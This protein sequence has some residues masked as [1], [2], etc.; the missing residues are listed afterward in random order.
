[1]DSET[2]WDKIRQE[3]INA[4]AGIDPEKLVITTDVTKNIVG[5]AK[6]LIQ[7]QTI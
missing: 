4:T 2:N 5:E 6:I 3:I 7:I 1:M